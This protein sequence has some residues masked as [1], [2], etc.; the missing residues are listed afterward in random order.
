[1][2]VFFENILQGKKCFLTGMDD[3]VIGCIKSI[4]HRQAATADDVN[5]WNHYD[6]YY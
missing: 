5:A 4:R 6:S 1:M 3:D 2:M